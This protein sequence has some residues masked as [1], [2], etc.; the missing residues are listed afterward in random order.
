MDDITLTTNLVSTMELPLKV[1]KI[2][3]LLNTLSKKEAWFAIPEVNE[4][5]PYTFKIHATSNPTVIFF[6]FKHY[7][8]VS[9]LQKT[10]IE[11]L[12]LPDAFKKAGPRT[13]FTNWINML[14]LLLDKIP[15]N[16][17][18]IDP[19]KKV[20]KEIVFKDIISQQPAKKYQPVSSGVVVVTETPEQTLW[21]M[22]RMLKI[23]AKLRA[24]F[25]EADIVENLCHYWFPTNL[26]PDPC[27]VYYFENEDTA[28]LAGRLISRY[29]S[30]LHF[31]IVDKAIF[32]IFNHEV[33]TTFSPDILKLIAENKMEVP[34]G[35]NGS[36]VKNTT[37]LNVETEETDEETDIVVIEPAA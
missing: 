3:Y 35:H 5:V 19:H 15:M 31:K 27:D 8:A 24:G 14:V 23:K 7:S 26:Q 20:R 30:E 1:Q 29:F 4:L 9:F 2:I 12:E 33:F 18:D 28:K 13:G 6:E 22:R 16:A 36:V 34:R 17:F 32:F 11:K 25:N 37:N 10:L 21:E